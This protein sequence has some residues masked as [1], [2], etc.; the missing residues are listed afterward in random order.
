MPATRIRGATC[1]SRSHP[2]CAVGDTRT[3]PIRHGL[4]VVGL[5]GHSAIGGYDMIA[6]TTFLFKTLPELEKPHRAASP[7]PFDI[8]FMPSIRLIRLMN[9]GFGAKPTRE[10]S[11]RAIKKISYSL[12]LA[13]K[14]VG[15]KTVYWL[16]LR[17]LEAILKSHPTETGSITVALTYAHIPTILDPRATE[18]IAFSYSAKIKSEIELFDCIRKHRYT[19]QANGLLFDLANLVSPKLMSGEGAKESVFDIYVSMSYIANC[20]AMFDFHASPLSFSPSGVPMYLGIFSDSHVA[21]HSFGT[22]VLSF[23]TDA[24][25]QEM[26]GRV[27]SP[28]YEQDPLSL[29]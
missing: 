12:D 14:P 5:V 7:R 4:E 18:C 29:H 17:S 20:G 15:H 28:D 8:L 3:A 25:I 26:D 22:D 6:F 19:G 16:L 13:T 27:H 9:S 1:R 2:G 23:D 11:T 10:H 24:F 21:H